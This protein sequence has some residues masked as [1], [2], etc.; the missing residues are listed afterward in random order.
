MTYSVTI[1]LVDVGFTFCEP[2]T[3][4]KIDTTA[5]V[6]RPNSD[7]RFPVISFSHG[8][9]QGGDNIMFNNDMLTSLA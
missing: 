2:Y 9:Y 3:S 1:D 6:W 4:V 8:L 7:G 5:N